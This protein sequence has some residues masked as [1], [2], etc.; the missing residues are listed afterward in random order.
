M[1]R[2]SKTLAACLG[3]LLYLSLAA[4]LAA[5]IKYF[6]LD[7]PKGRDNPHDPSNPLTHGIVGTP[8]PSPSPTPSNLTVKV[9]DNQGNPIAGAW[10]QVGGNTQTAQQSNAQGQAVFIRPAQPTEVDVIPPSGCS[11]QLLTF[12]N[13]SGPL[14]V[15]PGFNNPA[16]TSSTWGVTLT[17]DIAVQSGSGY[18]SLLDFNASGFQ[19]YNSGGALTGVFGTPSTATASVTTASTGGGWLAAAGDSAWMVP[20][21]VN[22]GATAFTAGVFPPPAVMAAGGSTINSATSATGWS[23]ATITANVADGM[24]NETYYLS[25]L[26]GNSDAGAWSLPELGP[27]SPLTGAGGNTTTS[28]VFGPLLLPPPQPFYYIEVYGLT[29]AFPN[30][31]YSRRVGTVAAAWPTTVN[32]SLPQALSFS[33]APLAPNL[34][35]QLINTDTS[36]EEYALLDFYNTSTN[37][38]EWLVL[39]QNVPANSVLSGTYPALPAAVNWLTPFSPPSGTWYASA[40]TGTFVSPYNFQAGAA[41][42]P[43]SLRYNSLNQ[44]Y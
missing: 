2:P 40:T 28:S 20:F 1:D 34:K 4:A 35:Y 6:W 10:V 22:G 41:A 9:L 26:A 43:D 37:L 11:P 38:V 12:Q 42:T 15:T 3:L 14:L 27:G 17:A 44:E 25:A 21:E 33:A 7:H 19:T 5:D 24:A 32:V 39:V 18:F 29:G 13:A 30:P 8:T 31:T 36:P 23:S 16:D